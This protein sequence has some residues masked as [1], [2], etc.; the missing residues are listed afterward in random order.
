MCEAIRLT[1]PG[2]LPNVHRMATAY[3]EPRA[4]KPATMTSRMVVM[5]TPEERRDIEERATAFEMTPSAWMRQASTKY[6]PDM[7]EEL[8]EKLAIEIEKTTDEMRT[9]LRDALDRVDATFADI[10]ALRAAHERR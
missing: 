6:A 10:D 2:V 5:M 3:S 8:L 7:S 4:R 9:T 1:T